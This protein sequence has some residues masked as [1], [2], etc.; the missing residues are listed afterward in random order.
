MLK[1]LVMDSIIN[2]F[3]NSNENTYT[4]TFIDYLSKQQHINII[5][6]KNSLIV[7]RQYTC[8]IIV[9]MDT[10]YYCWELTV[11]LAQLNIG[12]GLYQYYKNVDLNILY[13]GI[14]IKFESHINRQLYVY[15]TID[16]FIKNKCPITSI[17]LLKFLNIAIT[18]KTQILLDEIIASFSNNYI[19]HNDEYL[20][21]CNYNNISKVID[22][23]KNQSILT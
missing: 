15:D 6:F 4:T 1:L 9:G 12:G 20:P 11:F 10:M 22:E 14:L 23:C 3:I 18:D 7:N 2:D 17:Q 5:E 8:I 13:S 16:D 21:L 19:I